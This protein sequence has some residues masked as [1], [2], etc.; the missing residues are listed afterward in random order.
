MPDSKDRL[1]KR[2][3]RYGLSPIIKF[4]GGFATGSL[5]VTGVIGLAIRQPD[6]WTAILIVAML[7][8][9]G[10]ILYWLQERYL[11]HQEHLALIVALSDQ[12]ERQH[13][14]RSRKRGKGKGR[15]RP[16]T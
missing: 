12:L 2:L 3:A 7:V 4:L 8:A 13:R 16:G 14:E 6:R 15:K 10:V 11:R 9:Q 5:T 1:R